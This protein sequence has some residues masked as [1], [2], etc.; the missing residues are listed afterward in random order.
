MG[1][2]VEGKTAV[3]TAAGQGI[4]RASALMLAKEGAR[5]IATDIRGDLLESLASEAAQENL[6]I[7]VRTLDVTKKDDILNL[8]K[9]LKHVDVLFNCAGY[10]HQGSIFNCTDEIFERS[11]NI[12]VRSMFWMCQSI[13]PLIPDG[14]H[15]IN[16]SSVAS[17]I[18]GPIQAKKDFIARQKMGRLGT[19]EEIANLVLYLSSDES[20]HTPGPCHVI[21]G[22]WS[23]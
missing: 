11:F 3:I 6:S 10:V 22:G 23:I 13:A 17:S 19:A 18:K 9:D 14:G 8:A 5:V 21:D 16:M 4:G 15:I 12:N 7:T 2:R 1:G 20:S